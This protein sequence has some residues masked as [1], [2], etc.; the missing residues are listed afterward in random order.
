MNELLDKVSFMVDGSDMIPLNIKGIV[1]AICRGYIR[2]SKGKIPLDGIENV[3]KTVFVKIDS[4]NRNF[5]GENKI[6][7]ETD[8]KYDENCN[9]SHVMSYVEFSDMI[10]LVTILCHEIGHVMTEFN[11]CAISNGVYG[12]VKRTAGI[13]TNCE[14]DDNGDLLASGLYGFRMSDG[15]LESICSRIF[16]STEFREEI[17]KCG[18]DLKDYV[19]K[20][21]RLFPSRIY[22]EYKA[23]FEL[24]D[25]VMDGALF[26][27]SCKKYED[28]KSL[29]D[30]IN[31][32]KVSKIFGYLDA[33]NDALWKLKRYEEKESDEDFLGLLA[34]YKA[35]KETVVN[36]VYVLLDMYGKNEEDDRF[37][38]LLDTYVKV[39]DKQKLLP[40]NSTDFGTPSMS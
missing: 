13:Y 16:A 24:F 27:F 34:D 19:Y 23:C 36:L 11:P 12:L 39:I 20:D 40:I 7:G 25:Y 10:K 15:F 28:N 9:V 32:L 38:E 14:Y 2:E 8:T 26:D 21:E 33:S 37:K 6:M 18:I 22:D 5:T 31:K 1:K 4:D 29:V 17:L 3:C 30:D 35:K